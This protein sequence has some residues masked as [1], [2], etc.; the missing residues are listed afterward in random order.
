MQDE[1][2]GKTEQAEAPAPG[3]Q[4]PAP[5]PKAVVESIVKEYRFQ[6]QLDELKALVSEK[7]KT[8]AELTE[9][10]TKASESI[11]KNGEIV[12]ELFAL[13]NKIGDLPSTESK[14]EKKDTFKKADPKPS[15]LSEKVAELQKLMT[16]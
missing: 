14:V 8:I 4:T 11:D 9:K 15:N 3:A 5:A 13:V 1:N 7:D 6:E 16:A 12:K 10:F 2:K